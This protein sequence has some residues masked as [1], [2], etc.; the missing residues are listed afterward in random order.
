MTLQTTNNGTGYRFSSQSRTINHF[1]KRVIKAHIFVI[2]DPVSNPH[3]LILILSKYF[4]D[5]GEGIFEALGLS[6]GKHSYRYKPTSRL[7]TI[8]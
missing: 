2:I 8:L 4:V 5:L 3:F 7:D 1:N 6:L